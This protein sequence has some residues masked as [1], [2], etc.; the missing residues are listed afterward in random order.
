[1]K[2]ELLTAWACCRGAPD[3]VVIVA[4]V[5]AGCD[6]NWNCWQ[7]AEPGRFRRGSHGILTHR[8]AGQE[9]TSKRRARA[10]ETANQ[11]GYAYGHREFD[12]AKSCFSRPAGTSNQNKLRAM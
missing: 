6:L 3:N 10:R 2:N 12:M 9:Q 11:R 4:D 1:M 8:F 7:P 5:H